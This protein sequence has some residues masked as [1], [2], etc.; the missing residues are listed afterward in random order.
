MTP[1]YSDDLVTIY[2]GDCRAQLPPPGDVL[3][4]DP[5]Y[6]IGYSPGVGGRGFRSKGGQPIGKN[7]TGKD[8]V[9]GDDTPFDPA[10]WL[11]YRRV[12]L[13]GAN[14][15]ADR[16]PSA[17]EWVVW[18]KRDGLPSNDFAD[19]ELI[20][21]NGG[22]PARVWSH[23]W[24]G[25]MRD[26]ERGEPRLHPTQKPVSLLRWLV[27]RYSASGDVIVDPFMGSGTTL[28]AAKHLNR[29]AIGI[30]IEE[31]YCEIAATRCSQ[32]VLGLAV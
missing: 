12:V 20:W 9:R 30:E 15:Y 3:M 26:S 2:H 27:E 16:L 22:G 5:P 18:D 21:T 10:P 14:H 17:S 23:R 13:F 24:M 4:T 7:W 29:R 28:V 11:D 6:G 31:R 1:Y 19:C 32:E 25:L 8:I